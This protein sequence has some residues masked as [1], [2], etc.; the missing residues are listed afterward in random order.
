M[1]VDLDSLCA[2]SNIK[3]DVILLAANI[4]NGEITSFKGVSE[5][6]R[7][8]LFSI[9]EYEDMLMKPNADMSQAE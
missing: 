7:E 3:H 1:K 4:E 6:L 5:R 2:I 8:I 9:H